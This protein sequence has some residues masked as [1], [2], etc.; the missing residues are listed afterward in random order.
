MTPIQA[1]I[2]GYKQCT[3]VKGRATRLEYIWFSVFS[4]I[5]FNAVLFVTAVSHVPHPMIVIYTVL[6]SFIVIPQVAVTVRRLHDIGIPGAAFLLGFVPVA[7]QIGLVLLAVI[8]GRK[9]ANRYGNPAQ[10]GKTDILA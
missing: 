5:A 10:N 1:V 7:G 8:P 3:S 9:E 4:I 2:S 6:F